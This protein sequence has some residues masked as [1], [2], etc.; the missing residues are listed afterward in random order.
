MTTSPSEAVS[1]LR[2][3]ILS[4]H[5]IM[6]SQE[7]LSVFAIAANHHYKYTGEQLPI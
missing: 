7:Y 2:E 4:I 6:N 5:R 1:R 3:Y